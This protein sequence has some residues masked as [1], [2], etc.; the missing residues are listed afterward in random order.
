MFEFISSLNLKM[1]PSKI[2]FRV[3]LAVGKKIENKYVL[4]DLFTRLTYCTAL[5]T[6]A[7]AQQTVVHNRSC[8]STVQ[9]IH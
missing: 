8:S 2:A 7:V 3:L 4:E 6:Y 1:R 5:G 9:A